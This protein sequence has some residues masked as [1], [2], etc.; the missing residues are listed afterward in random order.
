MF[1]IEECLN[2][3]LP[4][5][6]V[7]ADRTNL[8]KVGLQENAIELLTKIGLPRQADGNMR[9]SEL[10]NPLVPVEK[11]V[12][13]DQFGQSTIPVDLPIATYYVIG[14]MGPILENFS[15]IPSVTCINVV[16]EEIVA[17]R[18]GG[19]RVFINSSVTS[20][21]QFLSVWKAEWKPYVLQDE[22]RHLPLFET[23]DYEIKYYEQLAQHFREIMIRL[24][25]AAMED[26]ESFWPQRL[27]EIT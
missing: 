1:A 5:E 16:S 21:F 8:V 12:V 22:I 11:Y 2:F 9:F 6:L 3:W 14:Q 13:S 15:W 23:Y 18:R 25:P 24:D 19:M 26:E 4:E 7:K 20:L 17:I 10:E 27:G